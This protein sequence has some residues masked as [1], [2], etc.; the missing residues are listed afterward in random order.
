MSSDESNLSKQIDIL[1]SPRVRLALIILV[2]FLSV[3]SIAAALGGIFERAGQLAAVASAFATIL[4]V[5]LT[6]QYAIQTQ[7]LVEETIRL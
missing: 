6:A 7:Q 3:A 1:Q 5:S 2:T 4:L